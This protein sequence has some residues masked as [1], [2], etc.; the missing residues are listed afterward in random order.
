MKKNTFIIAISFLIISC[1]NT[2]HQEKES[3]KTTTD[4]IDSTSEIDSNSLINLLQEKNSKKINPTL[5]NWLSY[6]QQYVQ[7]IDLVNFKFFTEELNPYYKSEI[8]AIFDEGF[9]KLYEPFLIYSPSKKQ[10][11]DID[12]YNWYVEPSDKKTP[13]FNA[14]QE[15]SVINLESKTKQRIAFRSPSFCIE[16]AYWL[17]DSTIILLE[18]GE[19]FKPKIAII[20]LKTSKLKVFVY[21][22]SLKETSGY[23]DERLRDKGMNISGE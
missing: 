18:N 23:S 1:T 16:D 21:K 11:I 17:S 9:D 3:N 8:L 4:L 22:N 5:Q 2:N 6:Y 10:Y 15:V 19:D 20:D 13:V 7:N 14:D 12:S